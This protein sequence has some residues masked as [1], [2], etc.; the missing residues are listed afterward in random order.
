MFRRWIC[1]V[2]NLDRS[3][4]RYARISS[5]LKALGIPFERFAAVEG[6]RID[7]DAAPCF[8]KVGYERRHGKR[9]TPCEIGCYLSHIECARRL[10]E[11][12]NAFA[13]ILEDDLKL[14]FDLINI[15]EGAIQAESDWD[16]LR[17]STVSSGRKYAFRALDGRRSLAIALT[18]EKGSGA[19]LINRAAARWFLD[20]LQP[21]RLPFDLA[22]DLEFLAGLKSAF[23]YPLPISQDLGVPS[24]IQGK[25]GS[26]HL[27]RWRYVS[28][29]PFRAGLEIARA[30]M[31]MSRLCFLRLRTTAMFRQTRMRLSDDGNAQPGLQ[32]GGQVKSNLDATN[33]GVEGQL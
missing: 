9:P 18:R 2:I 21:M 22:F 17:L 27:S 20:G 8:S 16:I 11:T 10:L 12:E 19:Y 7:P 33:L 31:R 3:P 30:V 14:P 28:V 4:G 32:P 24:Q 15:L 13:L 26:F 1:L 23:V 29:M 5:D 6:R 25:R